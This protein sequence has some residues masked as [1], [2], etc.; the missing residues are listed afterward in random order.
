MTPN[1]PEI[2]KELRIKMARGVF[3]EDQAAGSMNLAAEGRL[4]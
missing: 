2:E 4:Q 1:D 3:L